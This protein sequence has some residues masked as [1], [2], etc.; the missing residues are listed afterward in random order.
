MPHFRPLFVAVTAALAAAC[1]ESPAGPFVDGPD[2]ALGSPGHLVA[3]SGHVASAAGLREFTF[4]AVE[5]PDGSVGG[6]YKIVL[7]NGLF[8]EADVTCMGVEGSTGWVGG[9]IRATNSAAVV[10]G[11]TSMFYAID[12]GEGGGPADVV[13][14]AVINGA[15]GADVA[16]CAERPLALPPLTV[17]DGNVQV[18]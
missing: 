4:H 7:P 6:S 13:S 8:F 11:S 16:F 15:E 12:N 2:L 1:A 3:G 18:R 17:T 10:V 14:L 9:Q 5:H